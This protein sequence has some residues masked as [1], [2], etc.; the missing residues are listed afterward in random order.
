[1]AIAGLLM[2]VGSGF[3]GDLIDAQINLLDDAADGSLT[4][5][6]LVGVLGLHVSL[7]RHRARRR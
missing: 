3:A 1:M 2:G 7:S 5:L 4:T 6:L